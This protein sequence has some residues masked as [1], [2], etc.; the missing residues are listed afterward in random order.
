MQVERLKEELAYLKKNHEEEISAQ[1]S[2]V[3]G[4]VS[5]EVDS[6]PGI[7]LAKKILSD[8]RSQYE[9]M[10]EKNRKDAEVW[11]TTRTE[12]LNREVAGYTEQLQKS[13]TEVTDLRCTLQGLEIELQSQLSMKAP[14]E[15]MLRETE[16]RYAAQLSQIQGVISSIEAQLSDVCADTERQNQEYQLLMDIK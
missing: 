1:R 15:G 13:K 11:F 7:D 12:E 14:L 16:A 10:A 3:G 5:V 2:Q 9:V 8:M 4:Q 6:A